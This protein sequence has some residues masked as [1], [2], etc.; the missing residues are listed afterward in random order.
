MPRGKSTARMLYAADVVRSAVSEIALRSR[1][2]AVRRRVDSEGAIVSEIDE[3]QSR[4][5]ANLGDRFMACAAGN[6]DSNCIVE[7]VAI[8]PNG[9]T[10]TMHLRVV[11]GDWNPAATWVRLLRCKLVPRT[12]AA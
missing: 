4:L 3:P 6:V 9:W 11:H 8:V 12:A 5:V 2:G 10:E 1:R 7:V